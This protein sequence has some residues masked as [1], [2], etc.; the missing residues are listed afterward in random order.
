M[1]TP[2]VL[3]EK[4]QEAN[5]LKLTRTS[6]EPTQ[7]IELDTNS[8]QGISM[9]QIIK[10]VRVHG[11][12]ELNKDAWEMMVESLMEQKVNNESQ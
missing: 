12:E 7:V 4:T 10:E 11:V 6:N 2:L 3:I 5:K 8:L 9:K 1:K